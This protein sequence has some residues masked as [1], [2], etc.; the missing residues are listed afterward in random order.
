MPFIYMGSVL[1]YR[2]HEIAAIDVIIPENCREHSLPGKNTYFFVG[3]NS[4]TSDRKTGI[5][6]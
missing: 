6:M 4:V 2:P 1:V 5:Y 3:E